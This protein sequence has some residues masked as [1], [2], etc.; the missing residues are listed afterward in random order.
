M[1]GAV[2]ILGALVVLVAAAPAATAACVVDRA[3]CASV[4]GPVGKVAEACAMQEAQCVRVDREE[5]VFGGDAWHCSGAALSLGPS[6]GPGPHVADVCTRADSDGP[7][8]LVCVDG[9]SACV[10][11][12]NSGGSGRACFVTTSEGRLDIVRARNGETGCADSDGAYVELLDR[13]RVRPCIEE[14]LG[15]CSRVLL[16]VTV[17]GATNEHEVLA[18]CA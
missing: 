11:C 7:W 1:R 2:L 5:H 6:P 13:V 9:H 3:V 4:G 18:P 17:D 10:T 12:D 16:R 8:V 15:A 14:P